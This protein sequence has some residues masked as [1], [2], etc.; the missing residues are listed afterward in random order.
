MVFDGV[1]RAR[2]SPLGRRE[3]E[4]SDELSDSEQFGGNC[5]VGLQETILVV[6]ARARC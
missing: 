6:G 3:R 1:S 5:L 4:E 2:N